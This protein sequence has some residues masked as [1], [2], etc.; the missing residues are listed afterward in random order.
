MQTH[1][2]G[3]I[4]KK[5]FVAAN[6]MTFLK[7]FFHILMTI[8]EINVTCKNDFNKAQ[9]KMTDERKIEMTK[10]NKCFRKPSHEEQWLQKASAKIRSCKR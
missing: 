4:R 8:L 6:S 5:L 9:R 3:D 10:I 1:A 2:R 7:H